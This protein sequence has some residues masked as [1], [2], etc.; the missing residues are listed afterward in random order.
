M[1]VRSGRREDIPG[2][3]AIEWASGQRF[4]EYGLPHIADDEPEAS[5]LLAAFIDDGRAWVVA[6]ADDDPIG[7]VLVEVLDGCAHIEQV[8]VLP[9][10]QG[11]GH[12][13]A[14]VERA[15]RWA[16][17]AGL[18]GV[19]LTTYD[20]IPWNRPLYEHL[21]FRVLADPEIGRELRQRQ[22]D[23]A[24]RGIGPDRRV[25]MRRELDLDHHDDLGRPRGHDLA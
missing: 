16:R 7:F 23:E 5:E 3:R 19:T 13:R 14:L 21:G 1:E 6:D 2:V 18:P 9:D 17:A 22:E 24:G 20:H 8:S 4:R 11:K 25:A 12:G 15:T 10:H